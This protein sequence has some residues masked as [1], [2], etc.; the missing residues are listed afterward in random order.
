ME[1]LAKMHV[2]EEKT[3]FNFSSKRKRMSTIIENIGLG[4]YD[5]RIHCKG[6]SD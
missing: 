3:R 2:P 4:G 6:A 1:K 5:K